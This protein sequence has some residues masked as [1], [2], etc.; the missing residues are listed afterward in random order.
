M[1]VDDQFEQEHLY[2]TLRECRVCGKT[3]DLIDGFYKIRKNKYNLSSY[4][5]E[6]KECAIKRVV[7]S[8][9]NFSQT[10][11]WQYPDW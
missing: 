5:Y 2:L 11:V 9:K 3:K 10:S 7:E 6:C 8:R 4:A 1:N